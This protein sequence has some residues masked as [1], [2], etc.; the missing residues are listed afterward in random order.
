MMMLGWLRSRRIRSPAAGSKRS[1]ILGRSSIPLEANDS[2]QTINPM[3]ALLE[4]PAEAN[5]KQA[6]T[7][8]SEAKCHG[9]KKA[10]LRKP[11]PHI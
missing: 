11:E 2:S 5:A 3:T 7:E 6:A 4:K 1:A 8:R 10:F 9:A